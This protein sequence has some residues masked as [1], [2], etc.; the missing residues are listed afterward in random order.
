MTRLLRIVVSSIALGAAASAQAQGP[1][2]V[3]VGSG[4]PVGFPDNAPILV[5]VGTVSTELEVRIYDEDTLTGAPTH[6]IPHV[7]INGTAAGGRL[8][9]VIGDGDNS[10][11][12]IPTDAVDRGAIDFGGLTIGNDD[13]RNITRVAVEVAG[14]ITGTIDVGHVYRIHA[15]GRIVSGTFTGGRILGDIIARVGNGDPILDPS[16][17]HHGG[18]HS[19][20]EFVQAGDLISGDILAGWD[21]ALATAVTA[22]DIG[23]IR[24]GNINNIDPV[25]LDPAAA[26][27]TGDIRAEMGR[28]GTIYTE[29][30]IGSSTD[31]RSTILAGNGINEV[32]A[33]HVDESGEALTATFY[34]DIQANGLIEDPTEFAYAGPIEDGVLGLI[35]TNGDYH[36][37]IKAGNL[38]VGPFFRTGIWVGGVVDAPIDIDFN[39][40]FANLV[41]HSFLQPITIGRCAKGAIIATGDGATAG[42]IYS[43]EIGYAE[44]TEEQEVYYGDFTPGLV[45]IVHGGLAP[46]TPIESLSPAVWFAAEPPLDACIDSSAWDGAIRARDQIGSVKIRLMT[47]RWY[48]SDVKT[49]VPRIE[50]PQ[51]DELVIDDMREGVVWSGLLERDQSG[52]INPENDYAVIGT[53]NVG[54]MGPA[55]DVWSTGLI[56]VTGDVLG[57]IHIDVL[58]PGEVV[59]IG[60]RLADWPATLTGSTGPWDTFACGDGRYSLSDF[61]ELSPRDS[62]WSDEESRRRGAVRILEPDSLGGQVII[63]A[64][65]DPLLADGEG[66]DGIVKVGDPPA[67]YPPPILDPNSASALFRAPFYEAGHEGLGGGAVGL[68][69][70][71]LNL[72]DCEPPSGSSIVNTKFIIPDQGDPDG[73]YLEHY[74][75]IT[76]SYMGMNLGPPVKILMLIPGH[77]P[78]DVTQY[79]TIET[80]EQ[81]AAL[82][83]RQVRI[84]SISMGTPGE[85]VVLPSDVLFCD[86]IDPEMLPV[87]AYDPDPANPSIDR[88]YRFTLL[89]DCDHNRIDDATDIANNA[90][91]DVFP[92]PSGD[93]ILDICQ[94]GCDCNVD[95][96]GD[97]NVVNVFDLLAYLD[98]WFASDPAAERTSDDPASID[99]FDLLDFLDCWFDAS[100]NGCTP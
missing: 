33:I 51:I 88:G 62:T 15:S 55:A 76:T 1:I 95:P 37:T 69:P 85:Y 17:G 74:G 75:P 45:G 80:H 16:G 32:R 53:S 66:W 44:L 19:P 82:S 98:L 67:V 2:Q 12:A 59:R 58:D 63:N 99:V 18:T 65:A 60:G 29:G 36:G 23:S 4:T 43:V 81:N 10:F 79:F 78:M 41:A 27:I 40:Q 5:N 64:N 54:C 14:D 49:L 84:W 57:E 72:K 13:L 22:S 30:P 70:F 77:D 11:P 100:A 47:R 73:I 92:A 56:D 26:G 35:E 3:K 48:S 94:T 96:S 97:I 6:S 93:G 52:I 8:S 91:L 31:A 83:L 87:R 21:P 24:V 71:G 34:A 89:W 42:L 61:E 50:A 7:T 86:E 38:N 68:V 25:T 46:C 90:A 28:V 20:I 39:L 9:V